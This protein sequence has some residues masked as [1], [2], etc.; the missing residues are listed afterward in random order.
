MTN[1]GAESIARA[2]AK[3]DDA[4]LHWKSTFAHMVRK[5]APANAYIV[6]KEKPS[7]KKS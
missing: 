7:Q 1:P 3:I 4:W 5:L 6:R 2:Q